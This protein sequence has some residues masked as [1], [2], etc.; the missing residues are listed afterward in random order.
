MVAH[1]VQLDR[2]SPF[3]FKCVTVALQP[4]SG[5]CMLSPLHHH[6]TQRALFMLSSAVANK[7]HETPAV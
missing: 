3:Y 2:L 5:L 7:T 6:D 4:W 1:V